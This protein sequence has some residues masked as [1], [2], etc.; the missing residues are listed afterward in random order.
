MVSPAEGRDNNNFEPGKFIP[1][2]ESAFFPVVWIGVEYVSD[3][4]E[5]VTVSTMEQTGL[6][7]ISYDHSQ[8]QMRS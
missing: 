7:C 6:E 2:A 3:P 4:R 5:L 8:Y 1:V